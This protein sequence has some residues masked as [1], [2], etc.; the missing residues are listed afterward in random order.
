MKCEIDGEE[1]CLLT[2]K[3]KEELD[4]KAKLLEER[5][6]ESFVKWC[7]EKGKYPKD[8]VGLGKTT[9]GNY[10]RR[11]DKIKRRIWKRE[12]GYTKITPPLADDYIDWLKKDDITTENGE[13]Y[14][15]TSKRKKANTLEKYFQWKGEDW[16]CE[17]RFH[18][19][20]GQSKDALAD[21]EREPIREASRKYRDLKS[22]SNATPE[23]RDRIKCLIAQRL[24]KPKEDVTKEDWK[25]E[26]KK[27]WEITSLIYTS[28]DIAPRPELVGRMKVSWVNLD[29]KTIRIPK[30]DSVKNEE[31][32]EASITEDTAAMLGK[33]M[34]EREALP[35]YDDSDLLWLT[36]E[37][38]PYSSG[39]LS[40]LLRNLCEKAGIDTETRDISWYSIRHNVGEQ[41][42]SKGGIEEARVQLR[43]NS[44]ES[45]K[46][47]T[48]AT[49]EERR[50]TLDSMG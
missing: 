1:W 33:W 14:G 46:N 24:E 41:M 26:K 19:Y 20:S 12:G 29:K 30:E 23:E 15:E 36:R 40:R 9:V 31:Y 16:E 44:I 50:D 6:H 38:T 25:K 28:L 34:E 35:K 8:G 11:L 3:T 49:P 5:D 27:S 47:Y 32:W 7:L 2:D 18:E 39:P 43:H 21:S 45:T 37:G 22:Y 10:L 42:T 48:D 13:P 17:I 4:D